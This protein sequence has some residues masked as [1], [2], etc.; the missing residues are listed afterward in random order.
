ML[1]ESTKDALAKGNQKKELLHKFIAAKKAFLEDAKHIDTANNTNLEERL[2]STIPK[3]K[4]TL[5]GFKNHDLSVKIVELLELCQILQYQYSQVGTR[6]TRGNSKISLIKELLDLGDKVDQRVR[7]NIQNSESDPLLKGVMLSQAQRERSFSQSRVPSD[8]A[9]HMCIFCSHCSINEPIEN[10]TLVESNQA[11]IN[12]YQVANGVWIKY[13]NDLKKARS[14]IQVAKPKHPQTR[15]EMTRAPRYPNVSSPILQCH[16]AMSKCA[17]EGT[18][19]GSSCPI[20]CVANADTGERYPFENGIC[21]CPMCC[22]CCSKAYNV[23]DMQRIGLKIMQVEQSKIE[24]DPPE[25]ATSEFMSRMMG[26]SI[27]SANNMWERKQKEQQAHG[28]QNPGEEDL[29]NEQQVQDFFNADLAGNILRMGSNGLPIES[30]IQMSSTFGAGTIVTLPSGVTFDTK[31]ISK[32][33]EFHATNN[34]LQQ[35]ASSIDGTRVVAKGMVDQL[36]IDYTSISDGFKVAALKPNLA[37]LFFSPSTNVLGPSP[38]RCTSSNGATSATTNA[39]SISSLSMP[40]SRSATREKKKPRM[41]ISILDSDDERKMP[42]ILDFGDENEVIATARL[43]AVSSSTPRKL[44]WERTMKRNNKNKQMHKKK[45]DLASTEKEVRK[46]S[47]KLDKHM[48]QNQD[49][50][51][52]I[53]VGLAT[54]HGLNEETMGEWVD[55]DCFAQMDS[56]Q[57]VDAYT[58]GYMSD[59]SDEE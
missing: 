46:M 52:A 42:A 11:K 34:R 50:Y 45:E 35:P 49:D 25:V 5:K 32:S 39:T 8:T 19:V 20:K 14:G 29:L 30:I 40:S 7:F 12:S 16:C 54:A 43:G 13:Q 55:S 38:S 59:E 44:V 3:S 15:N 36:N 24:K 18:N 23:S 56:Q 48:R 4:S 28:T 58:E 33:S 51:Q 31:Q 47:K 26:A 37:S 17:Q 22:C 6:E 57:L 41:V 21:T 10:T 9:I 2:N 27:E 1:S 53:A